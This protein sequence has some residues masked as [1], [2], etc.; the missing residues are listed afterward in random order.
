M[1]K[2]SLTF[3]CLIEN[4]YPHFQ[5][6]QAIKDVLA[7]FPLK[8][9]R[10]LL[11]LPSTVIDQS[12]LL[13]WLVIRENL[14]FFLPSSLSLSS[15]KR[16][17]M[18]T[19]IYHKKEFRISPW[20]F[21]KATSSASSQNITFHRTQ[22][23]KIENQETAENTYYCFSKKNCLWMWE[24]YKNLRFMNNYNFT[25]HWVYLPSRMAICSDL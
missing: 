11:L 20:P 12:V 25:I 15:V 7:F 22:C 2:S 4:M 1:Q 9:T 23:L 17:L 19:R 3:L 8:E 18:G 21:Q 10:N 5:R 16:S 24:N 13:N 6:L 14:I